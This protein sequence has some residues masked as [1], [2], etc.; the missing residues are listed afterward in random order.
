MNAKTKSLLIFSYDFLP[1]DGG[2]AKLC[3]EIAKEMSQHYRSVLVLTIDKTGPIELREEEP[4]ELVTLPGKRIKAEIT[5]L[6][7]LRSIK[8]KNRYTILCGLW[9]PEATL[10]WLGGFR[11]IH[12]LAHGAEL[13]PGKS[14][15]RRYIWL[16]LYARLLF[17]QLHL[18]AN[19][20]FTAGL[21]RDLQ[22]KARI[23]PLP[24]AVD[25]QQ[26]Q[27]AANHS[28]NRFILGTVSRVMQ[29]KGHDFILDALRKLS[30]PQL[31]K[32]EWWIAGTG[33]YLAH[34]KAK[35][36]RLELQDVV[37]FLGFVPDEQLPDFY[38]QLDL[39]ALCTRLD[40]STNQVEGFGLVFLEAQ[41]SGVPTIGTRT[42]GIPSAIEHENGGWLID[43]EDTSAFASIVEHLMSDP[44]AL[45][46]A[47]KRA[48]DR[49]VQ[50][51]TWKGYCQRLS[52]LMEHS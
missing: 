2:I 46:I 47:K 38:Q 1:S 50:H 8:D 5:A 28:N 26:F 23:H 12:C 29:F 27:P 15:F 24:L 9:H 35:V 17:T 42:G 13:R 52:T 39:F 31:A 41:S 22:P 40:N 37:R 10:A 19:S 51:H 20:E 45:N 25:T 36:K 21:C 43:Q 44:T 34:L 18:I 4:F 14:F 3:Y 32:V 6:R 48:R 33:P 16:N 11:D 7:Y 30:A 49:V